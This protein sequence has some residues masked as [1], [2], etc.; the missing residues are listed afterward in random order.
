MDTI[1]FLEFD[2]EKYYE[3]LNKQ[4]LKQQQTFNSND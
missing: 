4:K 1:Y 3:E 2:K